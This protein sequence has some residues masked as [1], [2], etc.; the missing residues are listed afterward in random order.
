MVIGYP[1][2]VSPDT[3]PQHQSTTDNGEQ[4]T[5]NRRSACRRCAACCRWPGHVLLTAADVAAL[6][7][8]LGLGEEEFLRRHTRLASNRAQLSLAERA[9]GSC[10][11]LDG[12]DCRVYA[13]RPEQC[14]RFPGGWTVPGGCKGPAAPSA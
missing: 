10:V 1:F 5:D 6:S 2:S 3:M 14:R 4:I 7:A 8:F 9:D 12:S 13:A 11:F